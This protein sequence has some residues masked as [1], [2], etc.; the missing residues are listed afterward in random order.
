MLRLDCVPL[1]YADVFVDGYS[2]VVGNVV[3]PDV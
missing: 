3:F 1:S 2:Y